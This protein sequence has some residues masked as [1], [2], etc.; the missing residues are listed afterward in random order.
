MSS[1]KSAP[2]SESEEMY[3][4]TIAK[5]IENGKPSPIPLSELAHE[6][7]ILS[8]SANQMIRK[9]AEQQLVNYV[10]YRGVEL[11]DSGKEKAI[12]IIRYRR[13]WEVFLVNHLKVPVREAEELACRLEHITPASI[14]DSLSNFLGNPR[15]DSQGN[16]IP[17]VK[18][19]HF[20]RNLFPLSGA[21]IHQAVKILEIKADSS[22]KAFLS[23]EGLT[24]GKEINILAKGEDGDMLVEAGSHMVSLA[25][26]LTELIYIDPITD[27]NP[28]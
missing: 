13:L 7:D 9:L 21:H 26:K 4:V 23:H 8:V 12:R 16:A 15:T 28:S 10:P 6:M 11:N 14:S 20:D 19:K 17:S 5:L 3:L 18:Q 1:L 25:Q 27:S 24:V 22:V 2:L